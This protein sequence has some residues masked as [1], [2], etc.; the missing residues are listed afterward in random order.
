M[1]YELQ[2]Q[3]ILGLSLLKEAP[4]LSQNP[5]CGLVFNQSFQRKRLHETGATTFTT[6]LINLI[7]VSTEDFSVETSLNCFKTN[8]T[9]SC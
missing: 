4:R 6:K 8:D 5:E 2:Q 1:G 7:H 9:T 3:L